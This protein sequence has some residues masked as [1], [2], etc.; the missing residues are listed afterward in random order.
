MVR[1]HTPEEI[2]DT[3]RKNGQLLLEEAIIQSDDLNAINPYAVNSFRVVT[4]LKDGKAHVIANAMRVNQN[5]AQVIGCGDDVYFIVKP[6][7]TVDGHVVDD[8]GNI[9]EKHP[10]TGF[11]FKDMKIHGVQE[12]FDL[13]CRAAE[14]I[15]QV[16]YIG[17]DVAFSTKGPVLVEGNEY[18]GF[19]VLQFYKLKDSHEGHIKEIEKVVGDEIH[20]IRM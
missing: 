17:W 12:S 13:C 20:Q 7:G 5:D 11:P 10:L 2:Y 1:E 3:C 16:R 15:P 9:Y 8:Y 18:P 14:K 6:D 19:G 4:L